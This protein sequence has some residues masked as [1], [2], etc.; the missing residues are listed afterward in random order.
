MKPS[1]LKSS[2]FGLLVKKMG[3]GGKDDRILKIIESGLWL[4]GY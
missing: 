1:G 4:F 3:V 2:L